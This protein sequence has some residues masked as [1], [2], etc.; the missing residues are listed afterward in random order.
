[1]L[2]H[3]SAGVPPQLEFIIPIGTFNSVCNF[4]AKKYPA[5]LNLV[6]FLPIAFSQLP[7]KLLVGDVLSCLSTL[8]IRILGK[9]AIA[10]SNSERSVVLQQ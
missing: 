8:S 6:I 7:S 9:L 5:A 2:V 3:D 10:I 4:F 1:M